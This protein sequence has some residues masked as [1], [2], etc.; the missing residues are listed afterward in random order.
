MRRREPKIH[1][2]KPAV[3]AGTLKYAGILCAV[4]VLGILAPMLIRKGTGVLVRMIVPEIAQTESVAPVESEK[5][6]TETAAGSAVGESQDETE[7]MED[8]AETEGTM[9]ASAYWFY[10]E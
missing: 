9:P 10:E 3:G 4:V 2:K 7:A 5:D 8:T 1:K 6:E